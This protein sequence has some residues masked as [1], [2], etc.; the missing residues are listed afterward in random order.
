M[1]IKVTTDHHFRSLML[2]QLYQSDMCWIGDSLNWICFMHHFAFW[3]WIISKLNRAWLYKD[4]KIWDWQGMADWYNWISITLLNQWWS[5][6]SS[7]PTGGNFITTNNSSC[8]KV[9]F[10][11]ACVKNS[12]HGGACIRYTPSHAWP[13]ACMSPGHACPLGMHR[14]GQCSQWAGSTHPTGMHSCFFCS[15]ENPSM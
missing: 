5:D 10:S 9:M 7:I 8:R 1:G 3:T 6:V 13:W 11:Q 15:F 4:L 12:V 2:I 14:P